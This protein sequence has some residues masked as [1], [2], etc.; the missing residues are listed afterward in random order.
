MK[1]DAGCHANLVVAAPAPAHIRI[2]NNTSKVCIKLIIYFTSENSAKL[3]EYNEIRY[4]LIPIIQVLNRK[5]MVPVS[6]EDLPD[7]LKSAFERS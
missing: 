3:S 7:R 4:S 2:V 6:K 1:Q 5:L